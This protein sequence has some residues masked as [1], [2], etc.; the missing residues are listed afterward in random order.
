MD[1]V[2]SKTLQY[3]SYTILATYSA[4]EKKHFLL[5]GQ[6]G[7]RQTHGESEQGHFM[8]WTSDMHMF[9]CGI[10]FLAFGPHGIVSQLLREAL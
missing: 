9:L 8:I 4:G 5:A 1:V 10:Q 3:I 7:V 6:F 2:V